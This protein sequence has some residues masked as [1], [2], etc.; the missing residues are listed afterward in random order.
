MKLAPKSG[1]LAVAQIQEFIGRGIF[2]IDLFQ[3]LFGVQKGIPDK[4]I[5]GLG[6]GD[7]EFTLDDHDQLEDSEGL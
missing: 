6:L 1:I 2:V 5:D 7:L 3:S 4:Q